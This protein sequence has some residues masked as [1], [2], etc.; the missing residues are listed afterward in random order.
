[1]YPHHETAIAYIK[2]LFADDPV[3]DAVFLGGSIAHGYAN[4]ASDVDIIIVVTDA[5][6]GRRTDAGELLYVHRELP[7][8]EEGYVDGKFVGRATLKLVAE[9]GNE[10]T[11][12]AYSNVI[13]IVCRDPALLGLVKA[14]GTYPEKDREI[15]AVSFYSHMRAWMWFFHEARKKQNLYLETWAVSQ[16]VFYASRA[17][18]A[19]NGRLYPFHKWLLA[20]VERSPRKPEGLLADFNALMTGRSPEMIEKICGDVK[21]LRDWGVDDWDWPKNFYRDVES[22]WMRQEPY[23]SDI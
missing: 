21:E 11:R 19:L 23:I 15:N 10:A 5:E 8:W 22:V 9:R 3:A 16:F 6:Y 18:L 2:T 4:E 12:F 14:A 20:E 7:G 17:V 1:M 13:P